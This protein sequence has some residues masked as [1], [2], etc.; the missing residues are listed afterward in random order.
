MNPCSRTAP[1]K[2]FA[3]AIS[4]T[5]AGGEISALDPGGFG[6]VTI[7]K[8]LTLNGDG[9]LTSILNSG[10]SGITV[11]AGA[12]DVVTIRNISINGAGTGTHGIRY[13]SGKQLVIDK[14]NISGNT[15]NSIDVALTAA[16]SLVVRD[17]L[18]TGGA[19]GIRITGT[20]LPL[21]TS[22]DRTSIQGAGIGVDMLFGTA[23]ISQSN[24]SQNSGF[25]LL[26]EAGT[27]SVE[28]TMFGGNS[29]GLQANTGAAI[30]L[31]NNMIYN[32]LTGF[33]CGGGTLA[34]AGNNRKASNTGGSGHSCISNT[35][36]PLQ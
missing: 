16:G 10:T 28:G 25:G 11:S 6:S 9:G 36:I 24:L 12:S 7:T 26:A 8:A 1:C 21:N 33:G 32:N 14:C 34:S 30:Q 2:T 31:S 23:E 29:V 17:T 15:L 19:T 5:A 3:G 4:K 13:L 27:I 18:I 35:A 22:I 20:T